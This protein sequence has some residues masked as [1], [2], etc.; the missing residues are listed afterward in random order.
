[1]VWLL[2]TSRKCN[3]LFVTTYNRLQQA[4]NS[5]IVDV[6]N[7][8]KQYPEGRFQNAFGALLGIN[9]Q[10]KG[11]LSVGVRYRY[12]KKDTSL[13]QLQS[14]TFSGVSLGLFYT[15]KNPFVKP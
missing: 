1:M 13:L 6:A 7:N 14:N 5:A 4:I 15:L 9:F 2:Y 11:Q 8:S 10:W 12:I 3:L